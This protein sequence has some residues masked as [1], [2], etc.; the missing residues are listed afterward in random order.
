[1]R[2][3]I[4]HHGSDACCLPT[5][6]R[7][8]QRAPAYF[9]LSPAP[10]TAF[11]TP[12]VLAARKERAQARIEAFTAQRSEPSVLASK[13]HNTDRTL[14]SLLLNGWMQSCLQP[15]DLRWTMNG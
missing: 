4:A 1:M 14:S 7:W 6:E 3:N 10:A 15:D 9:A 8:E 13:G 12:R 2:A 11:S 5:G